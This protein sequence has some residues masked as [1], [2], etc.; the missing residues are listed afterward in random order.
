MNIGV[1]GMGVIGQAFYEGMK[2]AFDVLTYDKYKPEASNILRACNAE[3]AIGTMVAAVSGRPIFISVPTPMFPNGHCNTEIVESVCSQLNDASNTVHSCEHFK[4]VVVVRSTV[5]PGTTERLNSSFKCL[6][7]V[8]NPEF[9]TEA[10][11]IEDFKNQNRIILGGNPEATAEVAKVYKFAFPRVPV[12]ECDS[13]CAEMVK[14]VGNCFLATKVSFANEIYQI[15]NKM[16]ADYDKVSELASL[17]PRLGKSHWKVPG[18]DGHFGFGLTCFPKDINA[19]I[20]L[21]VEMGVD[22][23]VL[24]AAWQKNLEVRPEK[25]WEQLKGRAVL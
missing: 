25:D 15:C 4:Q 13:V 8:F 2:H 3:D 7:I 23:T 24:K 14:Y 12:H 5:P 11:A 6:N 9:L 20:T 16:G 1:I 18:P 17:D 21:A 22:P 10:N 19:L